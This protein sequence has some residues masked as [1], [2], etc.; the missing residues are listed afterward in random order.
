MNVVGGLY[1][2]VCNRINTVRLSVNASGATI[3]GSSVQRLADLSLW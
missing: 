3:R 1:K 2:I